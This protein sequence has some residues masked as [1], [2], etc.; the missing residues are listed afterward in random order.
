[1]NWQ[2]S[3][4]TTLVNRFNGFTIF[5]I[6]GSWSCVEDMVPSAPEGMDFLR[7]AQVLRE[8]LEYAESYVLAQHIHL[9]ES[10]QVA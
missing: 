7:Q 10:T 4:S 6:S 5:L 9:V 1:M 2:F 3:D 8:G